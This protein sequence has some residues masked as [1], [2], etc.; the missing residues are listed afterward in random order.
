M[1]PHKQG[2]DTNS[3]QKTAAIVRYSGCLGKYLPNNIE[4][5]FIIVIINLML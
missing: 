3:C 2:L 5:L 1:L 4:Y